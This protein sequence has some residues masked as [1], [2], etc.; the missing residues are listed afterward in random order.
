MRNGRHDLQKDGY[1]TIYAALSLTIIL[2]L[3]LALLEGVRVHTFQM[4]AQLITDIATDSV[5]A[6][7]HQKLFERYGMFWIDTS[8]G[9]TEPSVETLKE[10]MEWYVQQN[11]DMEDVFLGDYIYRDFLGMNLDSITILG[12]V[13]ASDDDGR[14]FRERA[15][16]VVKDDI[17]LGFL[18]QVSRWLDTVEIYG[19]LDSSLEEDKRQADEVIEELDG[20]KRQA[21]E[22]W[23]TIEVKNPTVPIEEIKRKG[24]LN[25][26]ID[27]PEKVSAKGIDSDQVISCRRDREGINQGNWKAEDE[28]GLTERLLWQEYLMRYCGFYGRELEECALQYQ[29]EY[30]IVGKDN[31]TDNLK[32]VLHRI[33]SIREAANTMYLYL[34][35]EKSAGVDAAAALLAATVTLPELQP[36]FKT[37]IMLGWAY[38]E[39][40]HDVKCLLEGEKIP[41]L[42]TKETWH[43]DLGLI[44]EDM[45]LD[46]LLAEGIQG[47]VDEEQSK[48]SAESLVALSYADYLRILLALSPLEKQTFR[49]MDIMEMDIRQTP[50]NAHF[51]IDGCVDRIMAEISIRSSYGYSVKIC[52]KKKY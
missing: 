32:G 25:L 35:Q 7:Y 5:L 19:L 1:L 21:G 33:I 16:E 39:S 50:G 28:E 9:S 48:G 10:H 52:K 3:Y 23:V 51:R 37:V 22:K 44:L 15:V 34:D 13:V 20:Q 36:V 41:L 30:L 31:D 2:S 43:Y 49:M 29:L 12:T 45:N 18:E 14:F 11:C 38:M 46:G 6:E 47:E 4:E 8:Y 27:H 24:V 40:L 42:K 17:G 26:V